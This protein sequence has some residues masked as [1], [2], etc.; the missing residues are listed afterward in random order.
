[1]DFYIVSPFFSVFQ[2]QQEA[3]AQEGIR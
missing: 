3:D 2:D 1:M